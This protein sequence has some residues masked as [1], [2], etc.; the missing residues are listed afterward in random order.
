MRD[1]ESKT[2]PAL[3][4]GSRDRG[5]NY[6]FRAERT[7]RR[8]QREKEREREWSRDKFSVASAYAPGHWYEE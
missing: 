2:P 8:M 4:E 1:R 7:L 6:A 3:T 5:S